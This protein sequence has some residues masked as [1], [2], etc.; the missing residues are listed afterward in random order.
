MVFEGS[1]GTL[2]SR[3]GGW[4]RELAC[5]TMLVPTIAHT[6]PPKKKTATIIKKTWS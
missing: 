5:I 3:K 6:L 2:I 4:N 1:C